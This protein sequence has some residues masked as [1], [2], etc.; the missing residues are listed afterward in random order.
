MR[1]I[2]PPPE[3]TLTFISAGLQRGQDE[4]LEPGVKIRF[5]KEHL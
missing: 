5:K 4:F 1:G 3:S 2:A